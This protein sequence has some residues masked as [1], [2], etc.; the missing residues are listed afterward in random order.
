MAARTKSSLW[1]DDGRLGPGRLPPDDPG[2]VALVE[3]VAGDASVADLGGTMSLNLHLASVGLVLRVHQPFV[4]RQRILALREV[5]RNLGLQGLRV[6]EPRSFGRRDLL[7]CRGRWAEIEAYVAHTKPPPTWGSYV[8]MYRAM[9]RLH[10]ALVGVTSSVPRPVLSTYATPRTLRRWAAVTSD[11]VTPNTE[12]AETVVRLRKAVRVLERQ[13][14]PALALPVQV[15]HGDIRLG[16][17]AL[18]PDGDAVY[19]DFGF[20]AVRPRVHDIA[21]SLSWIVLRPD[22]RGR[23]EDFPW[24]RLPELIW[25]Y[26]EA[27]QDALTAIERR[28]IGPYLAAVPLYLAAISGYTPDPSKHLLDELPFLGI[29]EWVLANSESLLPA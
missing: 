1:V 16:N 22:D 20:T 28:A 26:E 13:W 19:L 7:R 10:R 25:A 3:D 18:A 9:G 2:V 27:G 8:S 23:A 12:A 14:I 17:V 6:P 11:L 21:Y 24:D 4:T 15:I 5:R 29:A